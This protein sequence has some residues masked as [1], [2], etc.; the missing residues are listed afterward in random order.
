MKICWNITY[1]LSWEKAKDSHAR[2]VY[3][4]KGYPI[5]HQIILMKKVTSWINSLNY[6]WIMMISI[7]VV[8]PHT[9]YVSQLSTFCLPIFPKVY[10]ITPI[11][12]PIHFMTSICFDSTVNPWRRLYEHLPSPFR[13]IWSGDS[14]A[15]GRH[16]CLCFR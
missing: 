15:W 1:M 13:V 6:R 2:N 5:R 4:H 14:D 12:L 16:R 11:F 8:F 3:P 7:E 9:P 10:H